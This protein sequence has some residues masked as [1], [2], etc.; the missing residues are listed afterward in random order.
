MKEAFYINMKSRGIRKHGKCTQPVRS[1]SRERYILQNNLLG[2][3]CDPVSFKLIPG[4]R[5]SLWKTSPEV[6]SLPF[7]SGLF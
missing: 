2:P 3:M 5:D 1:E 6:P 4:T 7:T